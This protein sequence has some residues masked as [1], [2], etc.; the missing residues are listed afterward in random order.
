MR[1]P[2]MLISIP[3][4]GSSS[5][6]RRDGDRHGKYPEEDLFRGDR[7]RKTVRNSGVASRSNSQDSYVLPE[8]EDPLAGCYSESD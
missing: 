5:F 3:Q 4:V 7:P 1:A 2:V 6:S 8:I